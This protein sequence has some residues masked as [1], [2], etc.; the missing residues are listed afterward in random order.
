MK[1]NTN[2]LLI[3]LIIIGVLLVSIGVFTLYTNGKQTDTTND[4]NN[5]TADDLPL[6][7]EPP[8]PTG[9]SELTDLPDTST[10]MSISLETSGVSFFVPNTAVETDSPTVYRKYPQ[11]SNCEYLGQVEKELIIVAYKTGDEC[12]KFSEFSPAGDMVV[13][14]D[15]DSYTL[16][17]L[18]LTGSKDVLVFGSIEMGNDINMGFLYKDNFFDDV[19]VDISNVLDSFEI[20]L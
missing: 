14:G 7:T 16:T 10:T 8:S 15:S 18:S 6:A 13:S 17:K 2:V 19:S 3:F 12:I 4:S 9:T 1:N 20:E 5:I 11:P